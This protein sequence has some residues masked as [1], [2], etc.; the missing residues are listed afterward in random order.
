MRRDFAYYSSYFDNDLWNDPTIIYIVERFAKRALWYQAGSNRLTFG[1]KGYVVKIPTCGSGFVAN[2]WEGSVSNSEES[3]N[4]DSYVQYAKTRMVYFNG[5]PVVF[6]EEV[7]MPIDFKY[8]DFPDW[9]G[10]VDCGQV[11]WN[12]KGRLVAYDFAH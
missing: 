9:V 1:F 6:M 5:L 4:N 10:F 12:K 2:D 7:I 11:G 8:E 3:F